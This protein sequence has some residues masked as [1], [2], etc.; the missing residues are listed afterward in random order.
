M[1]EGYVPEEFE[2]VELLDVYVNDRLMGRVNVKENPYFVC[3]YDISKVS[4]GK[5]LTLQLDFDGVHEPAKDSLEVRKLSG[6]INKIY[7]E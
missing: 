5:E 4:D 6:L 7:V 1:I 2:E 3:E